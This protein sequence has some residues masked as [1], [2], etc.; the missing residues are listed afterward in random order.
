MKKTYKA[1]E[2]L[3]YFSNFE[4]SKIRID[5]ED[6]TLSLKLNFNK[7]KLSHLLG[8]HYMYRHI[9]DNDRRIYI[10]EGHRRIYDSNMVKYILKNKISDQDIFLNVNK[11][12]PAKLN[13]VK[14]RINTFRQFMYNLKDSHIVKNTYKSKKTHLYKSVDYFLVRKI[15]GK[16]QMLGIKV[17]KNKNAYFSTYIIDNRNKYFEKS[18]I[19][20]CIGNIKV[21]NNNK[22]CYM[23]F[24]FKDKSYEINERKSYIDDVTKGVLKIRNPDC[25]VKIFWDKND[26]SVSNILEDI[27]SEKDFTKNIDIACFEEEIS[28]ISNTYDYYVTD[29]F[30]D[31]INSIKKEIMDSYIYRYGMDQE[32]Y[33]FEKKVE[34]TLYKEL[35]LDTNID[36]LLELVSTELNKEYR[37]E[38]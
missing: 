36:D 37:R 21:Y 1:Y 16:N 18:K 25:K 10:D 6:N 23:P 38:R 35:N 20:K 7:N 17:D 11:Y 22:K 9:K 5:T 33:K 4:R 19:N 8:I 32:Y 27:K 14:N 26:I 30:N 29:F 31:E 3:K 12:N 28:Y 13:N 34:D 2:I 15:K 24:S